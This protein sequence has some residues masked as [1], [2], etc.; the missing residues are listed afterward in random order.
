M[1][2]ESWSV[3]PEKVTGWLPSSAPEI[4]GQEPGAKIHQ[5]EL[6]KGR[7]LFLR[8]SEKGTT[9]WEYSL[10][11]FTRKESQGEKKKKSPK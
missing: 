1:E 9:I 2:E 11:D 10:V 6:I 5:K 4:S 8:E 7:S 3:K